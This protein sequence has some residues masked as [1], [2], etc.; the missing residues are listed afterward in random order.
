MINDSIASLHTDNNWSHEI[1][2]ELG[3]AAVKKYQF[4]NI[5]S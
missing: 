4:C 1:S 3:Y 2:E 5:W